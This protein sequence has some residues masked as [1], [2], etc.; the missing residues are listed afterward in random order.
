MVRLHGRQLIPARVPV[1]GNFI[2]AAFFLRYPKKGMHR[3][4]Q[5]S[6]AFGACLACV[7]D[8]Y[9][10]AVIF[11]SNR[12]GVESIHQNQASEHADHAVREPEGAP[13]FEARGQTERCRRPRHIHRPRDPHE[14]VGNIKQPMSTS[15]TSH[16]VQRVGDTPF[17]PD[18]LDMVRMSKR[19][20]EV[21]RGRSTQPPR[22][23]N[24]KQ[25]AARRAQQ[26]TIV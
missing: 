15:V 22:M 25:R 23:M 19:A 8:E 9:I 7:I 6:R 20:D 4:S 12:C 16:R 14:P 5:C 17:I 13:R 11:S 10:D 21:M 24:A 18:H 26:G 2:R 1:N 3:F